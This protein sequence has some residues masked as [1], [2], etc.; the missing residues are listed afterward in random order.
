MRT[1]ISIIV[2][3]SVLAAGCGGGDQPS[4]RRDRAR[5]PAPKEYPVAW[6]VPI[7]DVDELSRSPTL[8]YRMPVAARSEWGG[9]YI[10]VLLEYL[11]E[12]HR[13]DLLESRFDRVAT[14][15][16]KGRDAALFFLTAEH[17]RRYGRK[18]ASLNPS[19]AELR[20][21]YELFTE[22]TEPSAGRAMRAVL[23]AVRKGLRAA[24]ARTVTVFEA[25]P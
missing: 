11:D 20:R 21:Y 22:E 17:R 10:A 16:V 23:V 24:D 15:A 3:A 12:K 9:Y 6:A 18:L 25:E 5:V 14:E 4:P 19:T 1:T 13:I 7:R 2:V 8:L